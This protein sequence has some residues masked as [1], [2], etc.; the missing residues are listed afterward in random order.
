MHNVGTRFIASANLLAIRL[1]QRML[2]GRDESRSYYKFQA[3]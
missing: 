1:M 3:L 2:G